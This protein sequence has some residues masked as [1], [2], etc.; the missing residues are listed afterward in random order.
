M[1]DGHNNAITG[2]I[3]DLGASANSAGLF[4]DLNGSSSNAYGN[5]VAG[6]IITSSKAGQVPFESLDGGS[7]SISGNLYYDT[8]GAFSMNPGVADSAPA[9][10]DPKFQN[11]AAGNYALLS[12]SAASQIGF[13]AIN[14]S[15]I[16]LH[17]AGAHWYA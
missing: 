8:A 17:P 5:K 9:Y 13:A 10:G 3:F 11:A 15:A 12:G 4:Q 16:G 14:Q 2:N 7:F 1:H 6:N